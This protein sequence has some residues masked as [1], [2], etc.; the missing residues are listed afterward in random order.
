MSRDSPLIYLQSEL[1][2]TTQL[3]VPCGSVDLGPKE[4]EFAANEE[5][6]TYY[7]VVSH[8]NLTTFARNQVIKNRN[9]TND[10]KASIAS[11]ILETSPNLIGP[12]FLTLRNE[13]HGTM[14]EFFHKMFHNTK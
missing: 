12:M 10:L 11:S 14:S 9:N 1:P 4:I 2:A 5:C 8:I 13:F 7:A 3:V 6:I